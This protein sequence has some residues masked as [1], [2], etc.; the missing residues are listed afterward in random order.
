MSLTFEDLTEAGEQITDTRAALLNTRAELLPTA[1]NLAQTMTEEL[2]ALGLRGPFLITWS[3]N[4]P[5]RRQPA[6]Y[7]IRTARWKEG[8]CPGRRT[9]RQAEVL[10]ISSRVHGSKES[11]H[12]LLWDPRRPNQGWEDESLTL[13]SFKLGRY[14]RLASMDE[15]ADFV[16]ASKRIMRLAVQQEEAKLGRLPRAL[17]AGGLLLASAG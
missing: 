9:A 16:L 3:P 8:S 1:I 15:L 14:T 10:M 2:L 12:T 7:N 11:A 13:P 17:Q 6:S 5:H 4:D